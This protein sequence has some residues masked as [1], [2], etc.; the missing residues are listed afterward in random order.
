MANETAKANK[1]ATAFFRNRAVRVL[2]GI[3][4]I[5]LAYLFFIQA[6]DSGN[7][8]SYLLMALFVI[9]ALR[10]FFGAVDWRKRT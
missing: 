9:I 6:I 4:S 1:T 8:L 7:L 3:M 2:V 5:G 10:E